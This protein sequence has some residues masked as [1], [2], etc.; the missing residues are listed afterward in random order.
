M[1]VSRVS[2]LCQDDGPAGI[3]D[4]DIRIQPKVVSQG[5]EVLHLRI[6]LIGLRGLRLAGIAIPSQVGNNHTVPGFQQPF[7]QGSIV[8]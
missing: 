7:F 3:S 6:V 2:N 4:S 5:D 8:P 1:R